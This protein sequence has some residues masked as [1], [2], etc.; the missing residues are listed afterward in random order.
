M[1]RLK[2]RLAREGR[3]GQVAAEAEWTIVDNAVRIPIIGAVLVARTRRLLK[4]PELASTIRTTLGTA[5]TLEV[6]ELPAQKVSTEQETLLQQQF[7]SDKRIQRMM[8]LFDA[9]L[10]D[11]EKNPQE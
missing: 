2:Q 5:H 3:I 9:E 11:V 6:V 4:K 1:E 7:L 8:T 10:I